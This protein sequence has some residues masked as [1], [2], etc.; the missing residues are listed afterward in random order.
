MIVKFSNHLEIFTIHEASHECV[1]LRSMIQHIIRDSRGLSSIKD[2]LTML[3][4]IM[5]RVLHNLK[6]DL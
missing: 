4:K 1:W 5:L 6:D 2:N 3:I